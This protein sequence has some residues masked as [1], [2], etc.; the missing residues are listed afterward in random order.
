MKKDWKYIL[1]LSL[2]FALF[3]IVKV[4]SPKQY[5]WSV[6][7]SHEDKNPYG[8]YAL[9]QLMPSLFPG[10]KIEHSYETIYEIKD[11]LK[12]SGNI[13]IVASWLR[14]PEED[15]KAILKHVVGGGVAFIAAHNY[16]GTL[17]DTLNISTTDYFF[18]QNNF[19]NRKDTSY[20]RFVNPQFDTTKRY[21]YKRDN[22]HN[23]FND[24][25]TSHCTIIAR[26]DLGEPIA[27]KVQWGKGYLVLCSTPMTLTNIYLLS[28]ENH[29]FVSGMLSYI[30]NETLQWTEY[31]HLGRN[32]SQ[33]PLRFILT[34]EPL[35]WAYYLTIL[36]VLAFMIFEMKRKQ[37]V[38]PV[39]T[40]LGNTTVQF[41]STI[42]NLYYQNKEHRNI[43][44]KKILFLFEQIRS[45][46]FIST[47]KIDRSFI[48]TVSKKSGKAEQ[49]VKQLFELIETIRS[50][51]Q[52]SA[53]MLMK[54]NE[55]I[56]KFYAS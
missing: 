43:A 7:Y 10:N 48:E 36:S 40:P 19:L 47:G 55:R 52:I 50:K 27:L 42:G 1:Y 44:E 15:T 45:R 3:I 34:T 28:A 5:D 14:I 18:E 2:A 49:E 26:N 4:L 35:R 16:W 56:E 20:L 39:I 33:T 25:D 51:D 12:R 17:R 31:Y 29:E 37:R 23:Y 41:V 30:P 38:I 13:F 9:Y 54:L 46:Y 22:I 21:Y 6:T 32:E 53:E 24:F 8:G 11:S